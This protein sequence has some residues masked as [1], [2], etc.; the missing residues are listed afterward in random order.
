M[1][2]HLGILV[3][4][5]ASISYTLT[6][7]P[8]FDWLRDRLPDG[9]IFNLWICPYCMTHWV[10][11]LLVAVYP[12]YPLTG[13]LLDLPVVAFAVVTVSTYFIQAIMLLGYLNSRLKPKD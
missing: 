2:A 5:T 1:L 9:L 7:T 6:K 13:S 12:V 3:L 11:A 8:V 10:A 4:A